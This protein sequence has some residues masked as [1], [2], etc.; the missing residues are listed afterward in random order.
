MQAFDVSLNSPIMCTYLF[1]FKC[2]Q[3]GVL[4][5]TI[6]KSHWINAMLISQ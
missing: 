2:G 5:F 6:F 4:F 1:I 3:Q